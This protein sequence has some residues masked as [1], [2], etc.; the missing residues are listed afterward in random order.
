MTGM[1]S[2]TSICFQPVHYNLVVES[3]F[4]VNATVGLAPFTVEFQDQS[5]GNIT[6]RHW[7]F[8]DGNESYEMNPIHTYTD[9]GQFTVSLTVSTPF[10]R[11]N[12]RINDLIVSGSPPF[13]HF[14]GNPLSGPPPL[15]ITFSD[16]SS[17]YPTTWQWDFGD[18]STSSEENPIHV[19][20][21][22]LVI[23][24]SGCQRLI[25]LEMIPLSEYIQG[26]R[27]STKAGLSEY[28]CNY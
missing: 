19:F 18:N 6:S 23:M 28:P 9:A 24:Q 14:S 17:G 13:A 10:Y 21:V 27:C 11:D 7:D 4:S 5:T 16:L 25:S 20:H 12:K 15:T 22:S 1:A 2:L 26:S 3:D 8:G